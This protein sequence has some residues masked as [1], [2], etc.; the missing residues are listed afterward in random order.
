ME[1]IQY[2]LHK[3]FPSRPQNVLKKIYKGH[4]EQLHLLMINKILT[5]ICW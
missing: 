2:K 3:R 4:C 1:E 5:D